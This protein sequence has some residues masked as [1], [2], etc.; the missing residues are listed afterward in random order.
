M[1]NPAVE[2]ALLKLLNTPVPTAPLVTLGAF[3]ANDEIFSQVSR[4]NSGAI[5]GFLLNTLVSL[6]SKLQPFVPF[7]VSLMV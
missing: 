7:T 1:Y 5:A 2:M 4:N 3:I 6:V